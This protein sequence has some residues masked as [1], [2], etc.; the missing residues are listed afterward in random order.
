MIPLALAVAE[1]FIVIVLALLSME[2][3]IV[4][5]GIPV[6]VIDVPITKLVNA[7]TLDRVVL[8]LVLAVNVP[9]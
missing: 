4:S 9:A 6:P 7:E 5:L 8:L 2:T 3:I 1:L